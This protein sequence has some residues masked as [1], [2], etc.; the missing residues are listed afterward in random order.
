MTAAPSSPIASSISRFPPRRPFRWSVPAQLAARYS[1]VT[2]MVYDS[3]SGIF[4][5]VR[6]GRLPTEDAA[7][8]LAD[9]LRANEQFTTFVVRLDN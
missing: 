9:Q 4:Y 7:R 2:I 3:P 6:V 5:R 1:P 8:Q